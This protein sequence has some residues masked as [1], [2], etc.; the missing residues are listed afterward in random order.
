MS[1]LPQENRPVKPDQSFRVGV[2]FSSKGLIILPQGKLSLSYRQLLSTIA[3]FTT[4][5]TILGTTGMP[6]LSKF[7]P[8]PTNQS[9][10]INQN[11][12][13]P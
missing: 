9:Q 1:E 2:I 4:L 13:I 5:F 3:V 10:E 8:S 11:N 7:L 6:I 12:N